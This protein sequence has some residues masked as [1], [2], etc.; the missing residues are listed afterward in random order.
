MTAPPITGRE[1]VVHLYAPLD[2]PHADAAYGELLQIWE[3]CRTNLGT[4]EA[5]PGLAIDDRLPPTRRDLPGGKVDTEREIAAQRHPDRPHEVI[6]RRHHDVLNLSVALGGD[7]P[8]DS[9]QR[10]WEDVLGPWSGALLGEDRVLCGHTEV[11]VAD[12]GDELP[13]RD[14]HVYR[15][16]EGAVGPHG[17]TVLEVARLPETRARRTLVALAPPGREDALSALVWS[18]GDAGIPPL[19]RFLLHAARLRY[20][21][22]VWEA[23]EAPAEDRLVLLHRVVE[24]AGDNLRL[25]LPDD[26]LGAD[27]PLVEDVRLA[28]WVTR[29]LEDDRFRRAHDPHPQKERPVPNPRE[30]FVIHGRDDQARRAVWSL[31]QAIDLR[32]RD[33]EEAVGRT[34]NLSPFLGDVVAKAFED[35]QAAVAIL[36]PDDAVHLHPELHGDHEDEFEKRPSMQARPNVLFELGMALALHPTRTVIIE[37]GSL[38]PF[39]DIGGRNVI[40][41]DGTPARSLAAIRKISERLGN[42]GCAVN[43]SGTDWLDTTRFTGLDAYKRHA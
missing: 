19:A 1:L 23:A 13:H 20:E 3:R 39:A 9:S 37:I 41:F 4:T 11:P 6:L 27:G 36:T 7:A 43:E 2:G 14:E 31:L 26:L 34:D 42:A 15:W 21:L 32:P 29:R 35:I 17:I 25:A 40:R 38:R 5:V 8:W 12:L 30:V 24:I 10:R 16:R 18:D 33:W 28:A 22:R